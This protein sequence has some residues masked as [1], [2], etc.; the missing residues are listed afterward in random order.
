MDTAMPA[1][2]VLGG[3]GVELVGRE[4]LLALQQLELLGRHDKVEDPLFR[5]DRA[6]TLEQLSQFG[7]YPKPYAPA[8]ASAFIGL[9]HHNGSD[10]RRNRSV[11]PVAWPAA[12]SIAC[13]WPR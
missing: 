4:I 10:T 2:G 12:V 7:A 3:I 1:E 5:A 13:T 9:G 8:V 6:V 11:S